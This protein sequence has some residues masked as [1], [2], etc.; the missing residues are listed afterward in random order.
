MRV[1]VRW[2]GCASV[3]KEDGKEGGRESLCS[4]H[5]QR[6]L[7]F[8]GICHV[9]MMSAPHAW[10][11]HRISSSVLQLHAARGRLRLRPGV[12]T[13]K[14]DLFGSSCQQGTPRHAMP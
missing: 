4:G 8:A 6:E 9:F 12:H 2:R 11:R 3:A 5:D 10:E 7:C 1:E 13:S 14:M